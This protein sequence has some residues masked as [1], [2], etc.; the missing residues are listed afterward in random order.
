MGAKK[1]GLEMSAEIQVNY[2][3]EAKTKIHLEFDL[4]CS[5]LAYTN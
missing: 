5:S 2:N 3:V 4:F 1:A